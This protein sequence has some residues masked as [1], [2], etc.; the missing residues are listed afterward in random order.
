MTRNADVVRVSSEPIDAVALA[1][2]IRTDGSGALA[3]F[4][5]VVRNEHHGRRIH[6]LVYEAYPP[7][8][9]R[10]IRRI[11]EEA[12]A[13]WDLQAMAVAHRTGRLG[14][15][16]ASVAIVVAASH[17]REAL[18]ACAFAIETLKKTVPIWKKEFSDEGEEWV[19]GDP[20]TP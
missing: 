15:G 8:A 12:R 10:E 20:S 17:R 9:E 2:A 7:M 14:I 11:V 16:E 19:V 6:H 13:R 1:A 5:G 4:V 18:E 3:S